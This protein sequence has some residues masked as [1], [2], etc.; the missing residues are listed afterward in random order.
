MTSAYKDFISTS[1]RKETQNLKIPFGH[2]ASARKKERKP[3]WAW[4]NSLLTNCD[5]FGAQTVDKVE[6]DFVNVL[7]L[8]PK[9]RQPTLKSQLSR[10]CVGV[11][12]SSIAKG[13]WQLYTK[14]P[15]SDTM[16]VPMPGALPSVL[17]RAW[18]SAAL[19]GNL[20]FMFC[21]VMAPPLLC[22]SVP[23]CCFLT[24]LL[25]LT[26]CPLLSLSVVCLVCSVF[27]VS[28]FFD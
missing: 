8:P 15:L 12:M 25:L 16:V 28:S 17:A 9:Q 21:R 23:P 4:S 10:R 11:S 3:D 18:P 1:Q 22:L 2:D 5:G 13:C 20:S 6:P 24:P 7:N 27:G 14:L 19:C 26:V